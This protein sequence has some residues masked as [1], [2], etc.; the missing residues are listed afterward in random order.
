ME[1]VEP[2]KNIEAYSI[3]E[4]ERKIELKNENPELEN[5][6]IDKMISAEW[7]ALT[8]GKN[9]SY[10]DK[11]EALTKKNI[12]ENEEYDFKNL[13]RGEEIGNN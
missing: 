8:D 9:T 13:K 10:I 7:S 11:A 6:E 12:Q 2:K 5:S 1:Q 3:Y 4:Q